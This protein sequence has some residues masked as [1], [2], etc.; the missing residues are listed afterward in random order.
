MP[1][2][3]EQELP[4]G[5]PSLRITDRTVSFGGSEGGGSHGD[6]VKPGDLVVVR[7]NERLRPGQKVRYEGS[8]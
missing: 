5:R 6:G 3:K 2:E 4:G 7:G 1:W 8:S